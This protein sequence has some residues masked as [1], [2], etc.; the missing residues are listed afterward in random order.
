MESGNKKTFKIIWVIYGSALG[1]ILSAIA[2]FGVVTDFNSAPI[3]FVALATAYIF[4]GMLAGYVSDGQVFKEIGVAG[5]LVT[6]AT[7]FFILVFPGRIELTSLNLILGVIGSII[8]TYAG[9]WAG[10]NMQHDPDILKSDTVIGGFRWHWVIVGFVLGFG[11]NVLFSIILAPV[12]TKDLTI[13]FYM[14][15]VSTFLTG[16]I[17]AWY[18]PGVTLKEPALAGV[19]A[20][21]VEW[22]LIEF[23]LELSVSVTNL[24][25]GLAIGFLLTLAG[26]YLGEKLQ[27]FSS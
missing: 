5:A 18:S 25:I 23:V 15:M 14:F 2:Y 19:L 20:V 12:Y 17:T 16:A 6:A 7:V 9:A 24:S 4:A 11:L 22:I 13:S 8:L 10:E 27:Q 26:A 1:I 21:L 3:Q